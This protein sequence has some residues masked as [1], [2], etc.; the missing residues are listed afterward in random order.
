MY[1]RINTVSV[2]DPTCGSG[3]FLF[4]AL[5]VLDPLYST[6]LERMAIFVAEGRQTAAGS[7]NRNYDRT[8]REV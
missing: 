2:L 1:D 7:A 3:A 6:C 5:L 4:A 8:I